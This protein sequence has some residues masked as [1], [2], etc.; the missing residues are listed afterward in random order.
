MKKNFDAVQVF[1]CDICHRKLEHP[2][3]N[4]LGQNTI[5]LSPKLESYLETGISVRPDYSLRVCDFCLNLCQECGTYFATG[6]GDVISEL[7]D[8][9]FLTGEYYSFC[10]DCA[11]EAAKE[12][13]LLEQLDVRYTCLSNTT[14]LSN[15][16]DFRKVGNG[17]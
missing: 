1:S 8:N 17:E 14:N 15:S 2:F 13:A 4:W 7:D 6:E 5:L 9:G 12:A 3:M 10:P 11:D 16:G